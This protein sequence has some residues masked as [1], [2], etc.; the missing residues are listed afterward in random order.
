M[1]LSSVRFSVTFGNIGQPSNRGNQP[2]MFETTYGHVEAA[3]MRAYGIPD[4]AVGAFRGRLGNLQKQGLLG[5]KNMPGRGAALRYGPDQIHRLIFACELF[6]SGIGPAAVLALVE[7]L[8]ESRI[9][10]IFEKAEKAAA[11]RDDPGPDDVAMHFGGVQLM[12]DSWSDSVPNVNSC[13]LAKLPDHMRGW[14]GMGVKDRLP[15]RVLTMNLSSRLR[16]FHRAL[17]DTHFAE[18]ELEKKRRKRRP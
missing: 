15:A 18:I 1:P 2:P 12:T 7:V 14:M 11:K 4:K 17:A 13:T 3:L 6:E 16:V 5:A 9:A 10:S 8:W